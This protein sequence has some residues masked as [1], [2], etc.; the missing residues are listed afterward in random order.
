MFGLCGRAYRVLG[1]ELWGLGFRVSVLGQGVE[2]QGF[3]SLGLG[4]HG[5]HSIQ[6]PKFL[7]YREP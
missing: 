4:F 7:A 1:L 6:T 5:F 2:A 3:G